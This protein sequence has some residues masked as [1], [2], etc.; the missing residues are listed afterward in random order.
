MS[1]GWRWHTIKP[2]TPEHGT[3]NT[4]E[5]AE[6]QGNST[7]RNAG[8]TGEHSA[9]MTE[10]RNS[11]EYQRNT[12]VTAAKHHGTMEIYKTVNSCIV[13]LKKFKPHFNT[14]HTFY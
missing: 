10:Q 8:R 2:E 5:T 12:N 14:F 3:R 4:D 7:T 1:D 11:S 13:F 6:L 9:T